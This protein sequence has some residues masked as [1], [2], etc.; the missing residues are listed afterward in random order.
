MIRSRDSSMLF[1][2]L[3]FSGFDLAV[4]EQN[5]EVVLR[6]EAT[7]AVIDRSIHD[8]IASVFR[9]I[10]H[11]EKDRRKPAND[12]A[13]KFMLERARKKMQRNSRRKIQSQLE[14][15]IVAL[16]NTEQFSY[17]YDTARDLTIYQFNESVQQ[18]VK[19]IEYDNR[20]IGV[21]AGTV[22]AKDLSQDDFNWLSHK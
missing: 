5:N 22:S 8:Q 7:G 14:Q 2:D 1:V 16:V 9:K 19:K 21:Y 20:M 4:N 3:D 11:I 6:D 15:Y 18:I 12:D 17:R 13:K 10:N